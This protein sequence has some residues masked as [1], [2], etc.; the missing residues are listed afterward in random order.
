MSKQYE[1]ARLECAKMYN[2]KI[3]E[4]KDEIRDLKALVEAQA[5][6]LEYQSKLQT[7]YTKLYIF[8]KL[9]SKEKDVVLKSS[10]IDSLFE[11]ALKSTPAISE[12]QSP[13]KLREL[14]N[15]ALGEVSES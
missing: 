6:S 9:S 4:L 14:L 3:A 10:V 7:D 11:I 12:L 8:S 13:Q 15:S 5:K 2:D 1:K